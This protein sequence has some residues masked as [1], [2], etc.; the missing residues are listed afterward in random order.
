[1]IFK[2]TYIKKNKKKIRRE[3][4]YVVLTCGYNKIF[5]ITRN[6]CNGCKYNK[7]RCNM[8]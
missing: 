1:M 4:L 7:R 3:R 8:K 6:T 5:L 2:Y